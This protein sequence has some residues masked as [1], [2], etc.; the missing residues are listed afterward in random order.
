MIENKKY[1][2]QMNE[3]F[4]HEK[5]IFFFIFYYYNLSC[6][7]FYR[8]FSNLASNKNKNMFIF[9]YEIVRILQ[10]RQLKTS[11]VD[12]NPVYGVF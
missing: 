9:L 8:F 10:I 12:N 7:I 3:D 4:S 6:Q 5:N 11:T 2:N 1:S